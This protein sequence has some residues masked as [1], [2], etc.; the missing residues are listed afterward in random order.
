MMDKA[1]DEVLDRYTARMEEE[2]RIIREQPQRLYDMRDQLLLS[3]GREAAD[4]LRALIIARGA[5]RI[6]E[7]GTSYG[8]STLFLADAAR[9]TGGRV[10][11]MDVAADKQDYARRELS[12][13][14]LDAVVDFQTGDALELLEAAPGPFDFVLLD[15]WKDVY[16]P[17]FEIFRHKLVERAIIA[18]D[19]MLQPEMAR[20]DAEKYRA[21]VRD[22]PEFQSVL[23]P[24][25]QGIELSCLWRK[26]P[27]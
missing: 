13:A 18:A 16:V 4:F 14:G 25:G 26:P 10:I 24:I 3:V 11:T 8:Y 6:L 5:T 21:A 19:N 2:R 15:I 22:H 17:A 1:F 7:L 23:L 12:G 9:H 27:D 20:P